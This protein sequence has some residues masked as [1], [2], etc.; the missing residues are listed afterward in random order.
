MRALVQRVGEAS[1]VVDGETVGRIEKGLL[2]YI[3]VA[4]GD[5]RQDVEQLAAKVRHLRIFPDDAGKMNLDVGQVGGRVLA[6]S[7]FTLQADTRQGRRPAFTRAAA[8]ETAEALYTAFCERLRGLGVRVEQGRFGAM[9][10]VESRNAGPINILLD[11]EG[12]K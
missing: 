4:D 11:T 6:V 1:V 7:S 2:V 12:A 10:S 8:P 9:M 3:G 5:D